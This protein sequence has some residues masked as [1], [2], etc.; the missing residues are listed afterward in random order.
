MRSVLKNAMA[1]QAA[2]IILTSKEDG[3]NRMVKSK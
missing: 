3:T 1:K 2:I